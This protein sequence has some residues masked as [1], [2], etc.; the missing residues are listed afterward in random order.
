MRRFWAAMVSLILLTACGGS[1]TTSVTGLPVNSESG[2]STD[3]GLTASQSTQAFARGPAIDGMPWLSLSYGNVLEGVAATGAGGTRPV[4]DGFKKV[5]TTLWITNTVDQWQYLDP[6]STR[7]AF[8]FQ[9]TKGGLYNTE[10]APGGLVPLPPDGSEQLTLIGEIPSL[11]D[12]AGIHVTLL[13]AANARVQV[14]LTPSP[15]G[16]PAVPL[17]KVGG[18]TTNPAFNCTGAVSV[19]L[20]DVHQVGNEIDTTFTIT[21]N[22]NTSEYP[23]DLVN[24]TFYLLNADGTR[25][26]SSLWD[27]M[28]VADKGAE[29][30]LLAPD[31]QYARTLALRLAPGGQSPALIVAYVY[32]SQGNPFRGAGPKKCNGTLIWHG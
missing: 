1:A 17:P 22:G 21:N 30:D 15:A 2:T 4:D 8:Q 32:L 6:S 31:Q 5:A 13:T 14:D 18:L 16:I 29:E 25:I 9:D 28:K 11:R 26:S 27:L 10:V 3:Q 7:A 20:S 19:A 24:G 12:L 23:G